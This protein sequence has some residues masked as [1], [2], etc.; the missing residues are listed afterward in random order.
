MQVLV[1]GGAGCIGSELAEA[2][3]DRGDEVVIFDNFSSGR[4]EHVE[5]LRAQ[6]DC[7]VIEAD[8]LDRAALEVAM[9]GV[10][11]VCHLAANPDVRFTPGDPTDRDLQ[12]NVLATYNVLETM[13]ERGV[14][15]LL[16]SST[17][18]V[19]GISEK[20]PI[21]EN[22][23]FPRPIS[24]YGATKL[25]CEGMITAFSHLFGMQCWILRFA[26][27]VGPK[28]R[29]SGRTVIS[30]FIHKLREN[31]ERLVILGDG[32]QSKSYLSS[33][34]CV[35][36]MLFA[37]EHARGP[38]TVLNLGCDDWISVTRIAE[39]VVEAMGLKDVEFVYTG[40]EAGWPGDVP[41]FLLDVSA[42]NRLGWKA[43]LNSEESV[44]EAIRGML[45]QMP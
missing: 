38:L 3:L 5:P 17:S 36:A 30:D 12:Q 11:M 35:E 25:A 27:I 6:P 28:V 10:E 37:V 33:R 9:D 16:F 29:K 19:Y 20:L 18:A 41:R 21:G 40:A 15:K 8:L 14:A 23:F 34:E 39:M 32:R 43:H 4:L 42:I 13:R 22:D 24:L 1:T 45:G 31:P 2:L 7:R 44:A 26:N